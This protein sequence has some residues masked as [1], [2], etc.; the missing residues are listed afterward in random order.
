MVEAVTRAFRGTDN[1]QNL[2]SGLGTYKDKTVA[3]QYVFVPLLVPQLE[4]AYRGDWIARKVVDIPAQDATRMW[5]EWQA[6][7]DQITK[8][9]DLERDLD[10]QGKVNRA[11]TLARLYG[12]SALILGVDGA[13]SEKEELDPER[14]TLDSL[15]F[16][17]V[18]HR[19]EIG[20]NDYDWDLNSSNYR[21]PKTYMIRSGQGET[22]DIHYTR[23]VRFIGS[24]IP[25]PAQAPD[26]WGDS[27]LQVVDTAIKGAGIV[28][29][30]IASLVQEA[31]IDVIKIPNLSERL[32][33][34]EYADKLAKRMSYANVIKSMNNALLIDAAEEWQRIT[35][36]FAALPDLM[37]NYLMCAAGAADIPVTRLVGQSP[38]GLNATGES[39]IRNY[40]DKI[41]SEQNTILRPA[42]SFLDEVLIRSAL[43]S[44]P[45]EIF[46]EWKSLWQMNETEM[47]DLAKKKADTFQIDV[48]TGLIDSNALRIGR[49]NQ[50]IEDG[51]YPGLEQTLLD[52]EAGKVPTEAEQFAHDPEMNPD[53]PQNVAAEQSAMA[54]AKT[55]EFH[56]KNP[57]AEIKARAQVQGQAKSNPF[58]KKKTAAKDEAPVDDGA[59]DDTFGDGPEAVE[60]STS[61]PPTSSPPVIITNVMPAPQQLDLFAANIA[62]VVAD[63]VARVAKPPPPAPVHV[64]IINP[65]AHAGRVKRVIKDVEH[66]SEGKITRITETGA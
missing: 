48:N 2:I 12:G 14:V 19:Y 28:I 3:T 50:L 11:M 24:P 63:A 62:Q 1:L 39:D 35:T 10:I 17:H 26:G 65:L 44:R 34:Q 42:L 51:T 32:S 57:M 40:Y 25:D 55:A 9:E 49:E 7:D 56:A 59:V 16:V 33:T 46:Y 4:A 38:R 27:I 64:R 18:V 60:R 58:G 6:E 15:K 30:G 29:G 54:Q 36:S 8:I 61:P 37:Q 52:Q 66:D 23:M 45:E 53:H 20:G 22:L 43:G 21:L 47:A 5:R 13:G 31:K 41:K